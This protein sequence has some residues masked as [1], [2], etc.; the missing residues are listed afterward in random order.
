VS[1]PVRSRAEV[2]RGLDIGTPAPGSVLARCI[3]AVRA[4][5]RD[6]YVWA[7]EPAAGLAFSTELSVQTGKRNGQTFVGDRELVERLRKL[8]DRRV[9]L[10]YANQGHQHFRVYCEAETGVPIAALIIGPDPDS[11]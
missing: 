8:D 5:D 1:V 3:A 10:V 11:S 2:L 9:A 4:G 6:S 7:T